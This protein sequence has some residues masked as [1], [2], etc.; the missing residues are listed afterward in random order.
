M[1]GP[2]L[3]VTILGREEA[4]ALLSKLQSGVMVATNQVTRVGT[5]VVYAWPIIF[6]RSRSGRLGRAAGGTMSLPNAL[7][8][9]IPDIGPTLAKAMPL[10]DDAT[11]KALLGLG[12]RVEAGAKRREAVR[13]GNLRRSHHTTQGP[14]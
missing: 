2:P 1:A 12:L 4:E 11:R 9:V 7:A 13:T 3:S 5:S 6:G 10:G 14:R 8:E